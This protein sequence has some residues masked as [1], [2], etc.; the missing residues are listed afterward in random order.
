MKKSRDLGKDVQDSGRAAYSITCNKGKEPVILNYIATPADDEL[1]SRSS[2]SLSLSL[3][4]NA[5]ERVKAK[6]HKRPS[7]HPAFSDA[8]S[9]VSHRARRDTSKRQNQPVSALGNMSVLPEGV[10]PPV[11]P[12]GTMP[13]MPL[14]H[15][16][17][18]IGQT[19]YMPPAAL[20]HRPDDMLFSPLGQHILDY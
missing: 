7:H 16:A 13:P 19:F 9:G 14:V 8:V 17:L 2:P 11:L 6:L 20:I 3:T 1:S 15:P 10:V 5:W 4:K 12:A 18:G